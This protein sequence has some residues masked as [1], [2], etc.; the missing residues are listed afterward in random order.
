[1]QF[2]LILGGC[3]L[4]GMPIL[5]RLIAFA[6]KKLVTE[7]AIQKMG[8]NRSAKSLPKPIWHTWKERISFTMKDKR[9]MGAGKKNADS[10]AKLQNRQMFF[11]IWALGLAGVMI[12][13]YIGMWQV[14]T[15]SYFIFFFAMGFGISASKDLLQKREKMYRRMFEIA[16]S[17][18]GVSGEHSENPQAVIRVLEWAD[19]LKPNK[20][21][22]DVPTTF[23]Q[24]GEEG[25]L[26]QFNQVFGN[27]T[28]WV[29]FDDVEKGTPGWNYEEGTATFRS[30][31]PLP[32]MAPWSEHYV[33]NEKV[34]W[35]F[36]P[37]A[38]G[39]EN[40]LELENP[41]TGEMENVL[42]FDLSG[43]QAKYAKKFGMKMGGEIT[44]SPMCLTG[45]TLV[46]TENGNMSIKE[47]SELSSSVVVKSIN[48]NFD[49]VW[50][51][52]FGTKL[53][54][55]HAEIVELT[56]SNG[57]KVRCTPDHE[58]LL[59]YGSYVEAKDLLNLYVKGY[60]Q[61]D[62]KVVKID[63]AG[64]EDVYDGEVKNT[65]NFVVITDGENGSKG[66][67]TSNCFVGGGTGGGKSLWVGTPVKHLNSN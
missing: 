61:D 30:V 54:R 55:R 22:F 1:M 17:K 62:L 10:G 51:E 41:N 52:M 3:Y 56:F 11:L 50:N 39:V 8:N 21:Q 44:T 31:P 58:W 12:G 18:L 19:P 49:F 46:L 37:I 13:A 6:H 66:A 63:D 65:H 57:S 7:K 15:I 9:D 53:T 26:R 34:A 47:I 64:F 28:S 23:A 48:S 20:V 59:S 33:V 60:N 67:L 35:S 2:A 24:E 27:E 45:D 5:F 42:G 29:A 43:E 36:F 40:G 14:Y 38:L 16:Q 4:I 25:F 32:V